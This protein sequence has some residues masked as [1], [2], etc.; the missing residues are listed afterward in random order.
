MW[1]GG[2]N[3]ASLGQVFTS[4]LEIEFCFI[5]W[6]MQSVCTWYCESLIPL[7]LPSSVI[8]KYTVPP[9]PVF[10]NALIALNACNNV[11]Y[12]NNMRKNSLVQFE[13]QYHGWNTLAIGTIETR[14][15][16]NNLVKYTW[17]VYQRI[18]LVW[19]FFKGPVDGIPPER[20]DWQDPACDSNSR[21]LYDPAS[22]LP[23]YDLCLPVILVHEA[24]FSI[25]HLLARRAERWPENF[26]LVFFNLGMFLS[27]KRDIPYERWDKT[28][29]SCK[30]IQ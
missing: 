19:Q 24:R 2:Q 29:R 8:P 13:R 17:T 21:Y 5:W 9:L 23:G 1:M 6:P 4:N 15:Y 26:T 25:K 12:N 22:A 10:K 3:V 27:S 16:K 18:S 28:T 7:T 30:V 11:N 14:D 20:D